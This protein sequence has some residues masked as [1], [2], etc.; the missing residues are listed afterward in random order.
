M[1]VAQVV[2]EN[3]KAL[4]VDA[5]VTL[6]EFARSARL[7]GLPWSTGRVGDFENGRVAPSFP[8]FYAVALALRLATKRPVTLADLFA[9]KG[10][11]EIN[12][13]L[14]VPLSALRDAVSGG[15]VT[16]KLQKIQEPRGL[17]ASVAKFTHAALTRMM[18][19]DFREADYRLSRSIMGYSPEVVAEVMV[20]LWERPFTAERDRR[21]E[22]GANPQRKGIISR[23]LKAELEKALA[24]GND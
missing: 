6:E 8:T 24:D 14:A 21:A 1:S 15:P 19:R 22:P 18:D 9:G 3:A 2:G 17:G 16:G 13:R 23:Q 20:K 5:R 7:W 11:V 4:R 10:T 12:D